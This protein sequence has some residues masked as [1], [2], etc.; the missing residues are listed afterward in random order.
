LRSPLVASIVVK[1]SSKLIS[2]TAGTRS[3]RAF[4]EGQDLGLD[5]GFLGRIRLPRLA[6]RL[7]V[8]KPVPLEDTLGIRHLARVAAIFNLNALCALN[9]IEHPLGLGDSPAPVEIVHGLVSDW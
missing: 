2:G 6:Y 3:S 4:Q 8:A 5:R 7:H 9:Q 1:S